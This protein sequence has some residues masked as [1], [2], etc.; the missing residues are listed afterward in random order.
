MSLVTVSSKTLSI[1]SDIG[2]GLFSRYGNCLLQ[3]LWLILAA[4]NCAW[5]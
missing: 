5:Y 3:R 1:S 4:L 2:K